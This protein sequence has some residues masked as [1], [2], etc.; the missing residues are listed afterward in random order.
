[1]TTFIGKCQNLQKTATQ[2]VLALNVTEITKFQICYL[3]KVGQSHGLQFSQL[4]HLI[5]NDKIYKYLPYI[6]V[7]ALSVSEILKKLNLLLK[8]RSK[9][10]SAIF[11]ITPFDGICQNLQYLADLRQ[12]SSR[13]HF[14]VIVCFIR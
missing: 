13:M 6:F 5:A 11:S 3:Q 10:Q 2:F 9:L 1:M 7:L 8:S 12:N 4:H 14:L